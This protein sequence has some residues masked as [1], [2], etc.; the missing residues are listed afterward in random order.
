[1]AKRR[2]MSAESLRNLPQYKGKT[3]T[4]L[5]E[6]ADKL[7]EGTVQER[8]QETLERL[9][10]DY[11]ISDLA[12]NDE[13][14]LWQLAS[15]F[16]RIDDVSALLDEAIH[17]GD[18]AAVQKLQQVQTGLV[19]DASSMQSDLNIT[20]KARRGDK[21]ADTVTFIEDLKARAKKQL[22]SRLSY[23]YCPKCKMLVATAWFL[24]PDEPRNAI[25]IKCKRLVSF[26]D[27]IYCD[28][29]FTVTS[30]DLK[31]NGNKNIDDVI[32]T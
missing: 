7:N 13:L 16:V 32:D 26:D 31:E 23:I 3:D 18:V 22:E 19:R 1:M 17:D 28:H 20:R 27:E 8:T 12:A 4:E 11:D 30:K 10:V 21:E 29:E 2:Q 24:Y 14:V 6:I 5:E 15:T 25:R 9:M